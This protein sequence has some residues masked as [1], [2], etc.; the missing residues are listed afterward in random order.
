VK[1]L[2]A[3]GGLNTLVAVGG[4]NTLVGVGRIKMRGVADGMT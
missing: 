4:L 2:V 1:T 3:V